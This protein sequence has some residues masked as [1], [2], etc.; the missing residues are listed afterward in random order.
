MPGRGHSGFAAADHVCGE[1]TGAP[2]FN[3]LSCNTPG[4]SVH[5]HHGMFEAAGYLD[6]IPHALQQLLNEERIILTLQLLAPFLSHRAA[7]GV[8]WPTAWA[9]TTCAARTPSTSTTS[10]ATTPMSKTRQSTGPTSEV[11]G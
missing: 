9:S 1:G 11:R 7:S 8:C 2:I 5:M 6:P 3:I 4:V 10:P